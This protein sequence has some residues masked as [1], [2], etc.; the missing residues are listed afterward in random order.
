MAASRPRLGLAFAG[1][2]SVPEMVRLA[3][4]AE[5]RGFESVW[6]AETRMTRDAVTPVAAMAAATEQIKVGT[7]IVNVYTRGPV[8]IAVTFVT[9]DELAPGRILMG[10]GTGSPL[11]LAPQGVAFEQPLTRLREYVEVV[12][13]LV[14]GEP[15]TYE[16]STIR[17]DGARIEDLLSSAGPGAADGRL[18]L[19]LGVTGARALE[20]AGQLADGVLMNVCLPTSY[21]ESRLELVERGGRRAGRSA[22]DVDVAMMLLASPDEDSATGKDRARRFIALYLSLF[23]NIAKET[24]LAA[25]FMASVRDAFHAEGLDAAAARV[26]D[27]VVDLLAAAGTPEECRARIEAYRR[28]GVGVPVL[29]AVD[30]ALDAVVET[31]APA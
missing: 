17:L 3:R 10:L 6:M 2:P 27:D 11:V 4:R 28:A 26:G 31:L 8:V 21:V 12:R 25:G 23:P 22:A 16:G 1:A 20:L 24:G 14:R 9:L 29:I 15:V 19:Y 30:G 5:E 7:G 13:P 18:P